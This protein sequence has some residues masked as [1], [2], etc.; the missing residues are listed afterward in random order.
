MCGLSP[1]NRDLKKEVVAGRFRED[2]YYR[3]NVVPLKVAALRDRKEDIPCLAKHFAKT[4][5][6][7]LGYPRRR[8]TQA[9]IEILQSYDWPGNIRE[10]RNVIERATI[11]AQGEALD[12]DLLINSRGESEGIRVGTGIMFQE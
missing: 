5:I 10:L 4:L 1:T 6:K 2:L 12:F 7:E 9:S 11:L 3:L 8:L